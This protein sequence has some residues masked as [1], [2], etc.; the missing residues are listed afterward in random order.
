MKDGAG[1]KAR[2]KTEDGAV[3]GDKISLG[4]GARDL[5]TM[6]LRFKNEPRR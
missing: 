3:D 4:M 6:G 1:K 5:A 2:G